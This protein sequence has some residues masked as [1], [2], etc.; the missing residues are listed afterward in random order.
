MKGSGGLI[1][2]IVGLLLLYLVMSDKYVLFE[3]FTAGLIG[4]SPP[5]GQPPLQG[6][7]VVPAG[8]NTVSRAQQILNGNVYTTP[9][10]VPGEVTIRGGSPGARSTSG[11]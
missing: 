5:S 7:A 9:P 11:K 1:L 8:T 2:V 4:Q 6:A 10:F 3:Q